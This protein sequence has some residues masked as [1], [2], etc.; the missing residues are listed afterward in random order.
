MSSLP[1]TI[2]TL[3]QEESLRDSELENL[4]EIRQEHETVLSQPTGSFQTS[5]LAANRIVKIT[6]VAELPAANL[7]LGFDS[8]EER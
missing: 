5:D 2:L 8:E 4:V 6:N 7:R 3:E 1:T